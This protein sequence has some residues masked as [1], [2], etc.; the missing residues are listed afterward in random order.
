MSLPQLTNIFLR[1]Q[2]H[3]F[4]LVFGV[5]LATALLVIFLL[6]KQ[7]ESTATLFV[8]E[9]RP[10]S[11]G[12]NAVQLDEVLA[13]TYAN[14]LD[15]PGVTADVLRALPFATSREELMGKIDFEVLTGTRLIQITA[16]D[17]D[18]RRARILANTYAETF[19]SNQQRSAQNAGRSRLRALSQQLASLTAERERLSG[20]SSSAAAVKG[21]QV[22]NQLS[23]ARDSYKATQQN[24]T[25]QGSNVSVS[26][27]ADEPLVPARPRRKLYSALAALFA[28]LLAAGAALARDTFDR[29]VRGEEEVTEIFGV[30]VLA[31]V[32]L[33]RDRG[34]AEQLFEESMQFLR[35]NLELT[36]VDRSNRVIA[37]TSAL[38]G[39]G[40]STVVGGLCGAFVLSGARVIAVDC[41][42]RKPM[43][44]SYFG[45][46]GAQGVTNVLVGSRDPLELV[47][48]VSG[49][50]RLLGSGPLPPNPAVLMGTDAFRRMLGRLRAEA[51]YVI[52]D[53][54]P[55][56]AGADT[57]AVT[58]TA[59]G[60]IMVI[61]IEQSRRDALIATRDQLSK[62]GAPVLGL[63]INRI[64]PSRG[65]YGYY[66]QYD[67]APGAAAIQPSGN[68][69]GKSRRAARRLARQAS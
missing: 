51:R 59:D 65:E 25:L 44:S 13:Q 26:S 1:R 10:I 58:G 21:E 31:R 63:V 5:A 68:G 27:L 33:R 47:Q 17:P 3:T 67:Y 4:L 14:L 34:N 2:L 64:S 19:V 48:Q 28:L 49:G 22:D 11:T 6:P 57:T 18:P 56:T 23:A 52:V 24:I 7:F 46:Q 40:K 38:P 62:A 16:V 37:V 61:D 50:V 53:T 41:D 42:L 12:A 32:P 43:L 29:R 66:G 36:A 9:N 69:G 39:D 54:P 20:L 45:A 15:T 8:G 55:V 35:A 60:V 30:P